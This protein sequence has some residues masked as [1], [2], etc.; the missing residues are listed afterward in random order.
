MINVKNTL[1]FTLAENKNKE[2]TAHSNGKKLLP[3]M[4]ITN[5]AERA[6]FKGLG[7]FV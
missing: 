4:P 6:I 1:D 2:N 7:V 5:R 3:T